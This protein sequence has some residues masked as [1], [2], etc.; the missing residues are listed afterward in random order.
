[1]EN[2]N[3][4]PFTGDVETAFETASRVLMANGFAVTEQR[5]RLMEF[6]GPGMRSTK[7]NPILGASRIVMEA[8]YDSLHLDAELG[9]VDQMRRFLTYFPQA[10]SAGFV[11]FFGVVMGFVFGQVFG[12][13]FGVPF[14]QG[15]RWFLFVVPLA[16]AGLAPWPVLA[17]LM[18]R[19]I[20]ER[21]VAALDTLLN[22]MAAAGSRSAERIM[23]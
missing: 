8:D 3:T 18:V 22:N 9:G 7:Q 17:P 4:I 14:A 6:T 12:M 1:M 19:G 21:T 15:W 20:R 23:K 5:D 16:T 13:G 2:S 11:L 10:M